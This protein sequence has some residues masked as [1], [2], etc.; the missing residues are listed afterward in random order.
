VFPALLHR[1]TA[2]AAADVNFWVSSGLDSLSI[3]VKFASSS[4]FFTNG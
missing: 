2:P 3:A 1:T 4:E